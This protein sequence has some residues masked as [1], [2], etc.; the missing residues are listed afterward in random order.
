MAINS[1]IP[2]VSLLRSVVEKTAGFR[3][4]TH[5]DFVVLVEQI[6]QKLHEHIS[7]TTLERLWKYSTRGYETVSFRTLDVLSDFSGYKSWDYFCENVTD[8]SQLEIDIV[9]NVVYADFLQVGQK[10]RI[11]WMPDKKIDVQYMGN[12]QFNTLSA[13]NS[14]ISVG[15]TFQCKSF[16]VG[17]ELYMENVCKAGRQNDYNATQRYVIGRCNGITQVEVIK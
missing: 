7:E 3:M 8:D 17:R 16:V 2:E 10:L 6:E 1:D 11:S 15:D 13:T 14:R 4:H 9:E 12:Y 5:S